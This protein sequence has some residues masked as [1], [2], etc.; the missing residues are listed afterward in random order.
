MILSHA[1]LR[2]RRPSIGRIAQVLM[3]PDGDS[4]GIAVPGGVSSVLLIAAWGY[5]HQGP[6]H[7]RRGR[8][9]MALSALNV[10]N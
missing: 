3:A 8:M 6:G 10:I 2:H 7:R 9:D 5:R 4:K 1:A